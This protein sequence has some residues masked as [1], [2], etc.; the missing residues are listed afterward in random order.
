MGGC[1]FIQGV[2]D[3]LCSGDAGPH[4]GRQLGVSHVDG[5]EEHVPDGKPASSRALRLQLARLEQR[6]PGLGWGGGAVARSCN[7]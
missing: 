5:W 7:A 6:E 1:N 3:S 2:R 4:T